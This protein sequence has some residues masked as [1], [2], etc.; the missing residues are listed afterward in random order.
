VTAGDL[1]FFGWRRSGVYRAVT[2]GTLTDGRLTGKIH[3]TLTDTESGT[4]SAAGD[5]SFDVMGPGDLQGLKA[6]AVVHMVPPPGTIDA[7]K[8][9]CV[10]IDLAAVDLPWRYTPELAAGATLKPWLSLV[11]G[12]ASQVV[13]QPGSRVTIAGPVLKDHDPAKAA[14]RAHVQEA[15]DHPG[16]FV[17]RLASD[18]PLLP[19]T[20]YVAVV[21]PTYTEAGLPAWTTLT[22]TVT[23]PVYHYWTFHTG[24]EGDFASLASKLRPGDAPTDLGRAPLTYEPLP[25]ADPLSARGALAPIG[26]TDAAVAS[27]VATDLESVTTAP[28]DPRRPVITVPEYGAP[29]VDDP[30]TTTWGAVF[31][32][33]PRHR[34]VAGLGLR[35]GIDEQELLATAAAAQYG[36]LEIAAQRIRH[37]TFGLGAARTLWTRRLPADPIR[38]LA[39]FGPSLGRLMTKTGS[40]RDLATAPARPLAAALFSSAARRALRPGPAR[41]RHAKPGAADPLRIITRANVCPPPPSKAP[42]GLPHTDVLAKATG[43]TPLDEGLR[44]GKLEPGSLEKLAHA[45]DRSKYDDALLSLLDDTVKRVMTLLEQGQ[46]APVLSLVDILDPPSGKPLSPEDLRRALGRFG[47]LPPEEVLDVGRPL[48]TKPP[49]RPCDPVELDKLAVSVADAIDPTVALPF[50]V[51]RVLSTLTGLDDQ[52]LTPPELCPDLDIPAWQFLRDHAPD[53]LLPGAGE[54][55]DGS[56]VAV[57]TNPVFIDAFLLG[58]NQQIL[59]ELR[60]RNLPVVAG[61]TPARQFWARTNPATNS[62]DDDIVGVHKWPAGS[63]L[64]TTAHQTPAA[65]SADLVLVF[66]TPLFRRYPRTLVYLTPAPLAGGDPDW[67]AEPDFANRQLPSF[68]GQLTPD[69]TFFGFDLDPPKGRLRWVVL[70]EPPHGIRFFNT[71][72]PTETARAAAMAS[73]VDG[74]AFATAAFADPIRVMIR[75]S[76]LIEGV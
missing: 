73:A 12:P 46:P 48:V 17:A 63:A 11:V 66:K 15:V 19:L 45:I 8:D 37:L 64:G 75:G 34:G 28:V 41:V 26:G 22:P 71:A 54:L 20:E 31:R 67:D 76:S 4:G 32:T 18:V 58:L 5:L 2:G 6:G 42:K 55:D 62:Y 53:W 36:A 51:G 14:R 60:F 1:R 25:A 56:V 65:A 47:E 27:A 74:G 29:W 10:H 50:V 69:I 3:L 44:H 33:D 23:L 57:E 9:K 40:V 30:D 16:Q 43:T 49:E 35:S 21:V 7:E 68:Q 38:R 59:A 52:P 24:E 70:E 61:C 39:V 13:I 72:P